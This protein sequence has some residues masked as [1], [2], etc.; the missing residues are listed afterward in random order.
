MKLNIWKIGFFTGLI[1]GLNSIDKAVTV[2]SKLVDSLAQSQ[3]I[4][5]LAK[6][7]PSQVEKLVNLDKKKRVRLDNGEL[8]DREFR[9]LVPTYLPPGFKVDELITNDNEYGD[10]FYHISYGNSNNLCFSIWSS[11]PLVELI[12]NSEDMQTFYKDVNLPGI[13]KAE[14]RTHEPH[15]VSIHST[16]WAEIWPEVSHEGYGFIFGSPC[17]GKEKK[18]KKTIT[19][20]EAVKIVKSL[21]YLNP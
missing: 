3:D 10:G 2:P 18:E 12:F 16:I 4:A 6:L 5:T 11:K 1:L 7:T 17:F 20:Q 15:R 13:G 14:L 8:E 9:V 19:F 21:Q